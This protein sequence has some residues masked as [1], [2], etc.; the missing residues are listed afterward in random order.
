M[1]KW[2]LLLTLIWR[3]VGMAWL[4]GRLVVWLAADCFFFGGLVICLYRWMLSQL[5]PH[6][7]V[8][9]EFELNVRCRQHKKRR[10]LEDWAPCLFPSKHPVLL[11]TVREL[12]RVI[13]CPYL[14]VWCWSG[15]TTVFPPHTVIIPSSMKTLPA[16]EEAVY[17]SG[18]TV[19]T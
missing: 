16:F 8:K 6:S 2:Y 10:D 14:S 1:Q 13:T 5:I 3:L 17:N 12:W 7:P 4:V 9:W 18:V 15:R 11:W 19:L